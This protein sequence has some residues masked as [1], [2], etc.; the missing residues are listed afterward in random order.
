MPN[1]YKAIKRIINKLA[2]K[3]NLGEYTLTFTIVAGSRT[4]WIGKSLGIA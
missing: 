2:S 1:E 4:Y 3:N